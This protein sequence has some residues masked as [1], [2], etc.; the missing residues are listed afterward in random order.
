MLGLLP[1][2]ASDVVLD[3]VDAVRDLERDGG[4]GR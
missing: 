4:E 1:A 2:F 3:A